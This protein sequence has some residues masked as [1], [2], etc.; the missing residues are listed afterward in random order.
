M[1]SDALQFT[2]RFL[3]QMKEHIELHNSGKF[4]KNSNCSS[5]FK[6]VNSARSNHFGLTLGGFLWSTPSNE[7]QLY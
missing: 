4:P 2:P 1:A 5:H 7:V 6:D 3:A